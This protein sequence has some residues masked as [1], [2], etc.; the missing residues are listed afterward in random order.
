MNRQQVLDYISN[1]K[2]VNDAEEEDI[3]GRD[4]FGEYRKDDPPDGYRYLIVENSGNEVHKGPVWLTAHPPD[5]EAVLQTC[6]D[7][8]NSS[9]AGWSPAFIIDMEAGEVIFVHWQAEE[10]AHDKD[11]LEWFGNREKTT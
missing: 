6:A 4:Q 9:E 7:I 11:L 8:L 5:L 2:I 3:F 1:L 10:G